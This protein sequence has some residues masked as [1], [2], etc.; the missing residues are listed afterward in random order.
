MAWLPACLLAPSCLSWLFFVRIKCCSSWHLQRTASHPAW[1]QAGLMQKQ[2]RQLPNSMRRREARGLLL[3]KMQELKFPLF[4]EDIGEETRRNWNKD[5][6]NQVRMK[7]RRVESQ[8][9]TYVS[10]LIHQNSPCPLWANV[11]VKYRHIAH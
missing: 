3:K 10:I 11:Q 4:S 2:N 8:Q 1:Q 5:I 9:F 6:I 7:T